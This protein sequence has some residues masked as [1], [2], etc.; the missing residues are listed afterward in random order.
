MNAINKQELFNIIKYEDYD[1]LDLLLFV[2]NNTQSA[3]DR[4]LITK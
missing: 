3:P 4:K 2:V 1:D